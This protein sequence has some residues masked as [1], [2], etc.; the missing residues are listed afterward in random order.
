[1]TWERRYKKGDQWSLSIQ[2]F[3]FR[4]LL[5]YSK[6]ILAN[7]NLDISFKIQMYRE[8]GGRR[9]SVV[10]SWLNKADTNSIL[11]DT[12]VVVVI[13]CILVPRDNLHQRFV[14]HKVCSNKQWLSSK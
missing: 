12:D 4:N 2:H 1:M 11:R 5:G 3:D 7:G 10:E 6:Y 13:K 9:E 14:T 8:T